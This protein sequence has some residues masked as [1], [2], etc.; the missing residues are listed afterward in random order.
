MKNIERLYIATLSLLIVHQIDAAYWKE[1][2]LFL[3]PG[4]IQLFD[5][6]NLAIIPFLVFGFRMV[7]LRAPNGRR[8]SLITGGLGILT[9]LIHT[10]FYIAGNDRFTLPVSA[11]I[12]VAC[13]LS[14]I[15]QVALTLKRG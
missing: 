3:L 6:L 2:E 13:G 5:I 15:A 10:G 11:L 12:V 8:W 14:G 9:L 4:G 7:L 1:W